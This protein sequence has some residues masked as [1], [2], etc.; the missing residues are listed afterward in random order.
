MWGGGVEKNK[1]AK[2]GAVSLGFCSV[3]DGRLIEE[4]KVLA[5]GLDKMLPHLLQPLTFSCLEDV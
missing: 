3:K 4:V 2:S 1:N 5:V